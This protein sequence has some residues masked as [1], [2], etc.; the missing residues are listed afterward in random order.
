MKLEAIK[1]KGGM[2]LLNDAYR[3]LLEYNGI[4]TPEDL[5]NI[6]SESVKNLLKERGTGRCMLKSASGGEVETYIKRYQRIPF[7]EALKNILCLKPYKFD[8]IHEWNVI[9]VF[10]FS[11]LN[12][13]EPIAAARLPDGRNCNLT[14]GI[15]NY[16]RAQELLPRLK[17]DP[18]RKNR[19]I[20]NVAE[21]TGRMHANGMA[22]QDLY[23]VHLFVKED[24]DDKVYLIDLQRT[25][26][27]SRLKWRWR[28]KDL[29]QLLFSSRN[30]IDD[31]D[32]ELFRKIYADCANISPNN[33]ALLRAVM[34]KAARIQA[35]DER[36]RK[37]LDLGED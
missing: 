19:L 34:K 25:I 29:A 11:D 27:Q 33:T 12:T 24:E 1:N 16:T 3:E 14:L 4:F 23:L 2:L 9:V 22:H 5:W 31:S 36:R 26:A 13:M 7:R 21:L 37:R 18:V 28:V 20:R 32:I 8:G 17:D 6:N 30:Y 35:H 10:H 15:T